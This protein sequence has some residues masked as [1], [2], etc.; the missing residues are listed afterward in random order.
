MQY[1]YIQKY[2]LYNEYLTILLMNDTLLIPPTSSSYLV[3]PFFLC[4][5]YFA[6]LLQAP[7]LVGGTVGLSLQPLSNISKHPFIER[8]KFTSW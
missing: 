4:A 2:I 3:I 8:A 7:N 6:S 1:Q 5:N